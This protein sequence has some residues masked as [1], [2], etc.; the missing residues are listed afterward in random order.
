MGETL[1]QIL[2]RLPGKNCGDCGFRTCAG[3][4]ERL[5][6]RPEDLYIWCLNKPRCPLLPT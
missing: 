6:A 4:A 5:L 3:F 1:E 2:A